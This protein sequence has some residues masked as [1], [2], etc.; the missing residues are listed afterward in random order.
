LHGGETGE[1]LAGSKWVSMPIERPGLEGP[2]VH[3]REHVRGVQLVDA[4]EVIS[5][6]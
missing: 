3:L 1:V 4:A 5:E 6:A 2:A